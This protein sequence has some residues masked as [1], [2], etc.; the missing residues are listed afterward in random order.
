VFSE[1]GTPKVRYVRGGTL[2]DPTGITP[3]VHI[4]TRSKADWVTIPP[5]TPAYEV[6]Y[7]TSKLWPAESLRRLEAVV[8]RAQ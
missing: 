6:Y 1:Y 8:P 5:R 2:D 4:Y 7:D 3:D